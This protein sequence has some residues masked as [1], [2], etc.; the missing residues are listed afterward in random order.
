MTFDAGH[1]LSGSTWTSTNGLFTLSSSDMS[2]IA[3]LA[4]DATGP[5]VRFGG[6]NGEFYSS[7]YTPPQEWLR[8]EPPLHITANV[9]VPYLNQSWASIFGFMQDNG[10]YE[11]GF[12]LGFHNDDMY[13]AVATDTDGLGSYNTCPDSTIAGQWVELD[14]LYDG[15]QVTLDINGVRCSPF[16]TRML[17]GNVSWPDISSELVIGSYL[18]NNEKS[19][20]EVDVRRIVWHADNCPP[21]APPPPTRATVGGM[22]VQAHASPAAPGAAA[23]RQHPSHSPHARSAQMILSSLGPMGCHTRCEACRGAPSTCSRRLASP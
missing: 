7:S 19:P 16:T 9:R 14:A 21:S 5:Y 1:G 15:A 2:A 12:V 3:V 8:E 17:T 11:K 20:L 13:F 10:R 23:A 22:P 18:D 4:H 6:A